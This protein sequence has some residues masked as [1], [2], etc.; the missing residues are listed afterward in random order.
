MRIKKMME[1]QTKHK[2]S[3]RLNFMQ[4]EIQMSY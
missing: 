2:S 1:M 4:Y 3:S